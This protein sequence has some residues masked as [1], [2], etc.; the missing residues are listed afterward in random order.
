VATEK[1]VRDEETPYEP[2][3]GETRQ[4]W[5]DIILGVNDGLV[6]MFLLVVGVVGGGL[7]ADQ[8][9][10]TAVAG[11]LAGSVSMAA[12]EYLA[13]KSQDQVLEA[14]L[15][16]ERVHISEHRQQ[17]LDQL[18]EMFGDMGLRPEDVDM[19]VAA[20][21]RSDEAI[22]NAMKAL[23]FGFVDSER[24]SPYRAMA[25]SGLL[26]LVGALPSIL[27][28]LVFEDVRVGLL[29]AS[30]L[31]LVGL[32]AVGVVKARVARNNWFASGLENMVIA[33][34]GGVIAWLIG[35]MVGTALV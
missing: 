2:H 15:K 1:R 4:Y 25:A 24:R 16:L 28:F 21:D 9:L 19:V 29:W 22:L 30:V 18:T 31:A 8:V 35:D 17:E 12:G 33:G 32:F 3:I 11:A 23:E 6:S 5:R 14:E 13:T 27:P 20:F 26:F 10:L 7:D 34:V